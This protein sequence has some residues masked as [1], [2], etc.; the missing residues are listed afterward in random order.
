MSSQ[1]LTQLQQAQASG[2]VAYYKNFFND[3]L[4]E[5][6]QLEGK[7]AG[8]LLVSVIVIATFFFKNLFRYLALFVMAPVRFG[9][10]KR[11]RQ[12]LYKKL[13]NLP[14]SYFSEERKG[15]LMSRISLDVQEI[16]WSIFTIGR[17]SCTLTDYDYRVLSRDVLY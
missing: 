7:K 13:L 5:Y 6:I 4:A 12:E 2:F 15:D 9:I 1:L 16:Q 10:E 17:S 11:I 3:A 14:L 8:L